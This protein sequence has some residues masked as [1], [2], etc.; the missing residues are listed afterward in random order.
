MPLYDIPAFTR[1]LG[2]KQ[3]RWYSHDPATLRLVDSR[4]RDLANPHRGNFA[5][6]D[7][8]QIDWLTESLEGAIVAGPSFLD[9]A[10]KGTLPQVSWIDPNFVDLSVLET[11]SN[12]DHPPS[13]IRA[14]QAF[15]F[16][17]YD[18]LIRSPAWPDTLLDRGLRRAR[19]VL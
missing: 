19:R 17:V 6:F 16:D 10:A 14:G 2:D 12:D 9:D 15:I 13:D 7:R 4:Y 11:A 3:W 5:F 8:R 18:A 1:Q